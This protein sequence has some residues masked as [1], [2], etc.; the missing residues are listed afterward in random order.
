[1]PR[2]KIH[3]S[4]SVKISVNASP[5]QDR[6]LRSAA[7]AA[8]MG[9]DRS[10]WMLAHSIKAA[11]LGAGDESALSPVLISGQLAERIRAAAKEQGIAP[12]AIVQQWAAAF[13]PVRAAG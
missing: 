1:M 12:D 2:K 11:L 5:E 4:G 8:G 3:T 9:K 6:L 7:E 13:D 10:G